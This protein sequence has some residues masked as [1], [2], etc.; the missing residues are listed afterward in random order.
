MLHSTTITSA[1]RTAILI[2]AL[3]VSSIVAFASM[4]GGGERKKKSAPLLS[5]LSVVEPC[6]KPTLGTFSLKS[7]F[8]YRGNQ[9][10]EEKHERFVMYN[11]VVTYKNGN[12]IHILPYK[13][14]VIL[15]KF[16]TPTPEKH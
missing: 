13:H 9:L 7:S 12:T 6:L 4:G 15:Q 10:L 5:G 14:K 2:A 11:S 3:C 16:K 1:R 8:N